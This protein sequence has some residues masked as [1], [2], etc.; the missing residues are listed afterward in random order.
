MLLTIGIPVYNG[1]KTIKKTLQSI[2]SAA[3]GKGADNFE[4][5]ISD[6]AST[7]NTRAVLEEIGTQFPDIIRCRFNDAN[8]GFDANIDQIVLSARG[9]YVWLLGCGEILSL[10]SLEVIFKELV[11]SKYDNILLNFDIY[12]EENNIFSS[13]SVFDGTIYGTYKSSDLFFRETITGIT[14]LSANIVKTS[15]YLKIINI[16]LYEVGWGHVERIVDM[17]AREEYS[18]SFVIGDICFTLIRENDGW[19]T[20]SG[21]LLKNNLSLYRII[22][23]M[24]AKGYSPTT[25]KCITDHMANVSSLVSYIITAGK[26]GITVDSSTRAEMKKLYGKRLGFWLIVFPVSLI[27]GSFWTSKVYKNTINLAKRIIKRRVA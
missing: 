13:I 24:S 9:K 26:Q 20:R 19:W 21:N 27:P 1:E 10:R 12:E 3:A 4:V 17:L 14:P 22:S 5:L 15:S 25:V 2:L 11:S 7:D 18:G 8:L 23:R 16:P 6:N